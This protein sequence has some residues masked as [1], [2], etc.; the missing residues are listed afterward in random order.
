[1]TDNYRRLSYQRKLLSV[2]PVP[3]LEYWPLSERSGS[4][5]LDVSGNGRHGAYTA[6]TLGKAGRGDGSTAIG[7]DGSTS[8]CNVY[9]TSLR[10]SFPTAK[11]AVSIWFQASAAG[12]WTD[13]AVRRAFSFQVDANNRVYA[14]KPAA[15][16]I[17]DMYYVA[18]G[19]SKNVRKSSFSPAGWTHMALTWDATADQVIGYINAVQVGAILTGLGTWS[20]V[21]VSTN[22]NIGAN[23]TTPTS[24]WSGNLEDAAVWPLALPPGAIAELYTTGLSGL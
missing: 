23:A 4:V 5:A 13:G 17:F 7:L 11:G 14:E 22:C 19:T 16:N 18:G 2:S 10:D 8:L 12:V 20:G 1:M 6:C 9:S 24:V 3:P 15:S 21:L